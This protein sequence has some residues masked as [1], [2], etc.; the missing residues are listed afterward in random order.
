MATGD[1][2]NAFMAQVGGH[3][4]N[5]KSD[6]T[7]A[8]GG[9]FITRNLNNIV[10]GIGAGGAVALGAAL[11]P[12][13][14][15][16]SLIPALALAAGGGA[17]GGGLGEASK[18]AAEGNYG[19][20]QSLKEIRNQAL[21]QG[22]LGAAGEGAGSL[23]GHF[24]PAATEGGGAITRGL[25]N[26]SGKKIAQQVASNLPKDAL[27][28]GNDVARLTSNSELLSGLG[29]YNNAQRQTAG[30]L[31]NDFLGS[32]KNEALSK[33]GSV[34]IL[35]GLGQKI[36]AAITD[37]GVAQGDSK[38]I[39]G[40]VNSAVNK[41]IGSE[42]AVGNQAASAADVFKIQSKLEK[43]GIAAS[44]SGDAE[45]AAAYRDLASHFAN[46]IDTHAG[47]NASIA[48]LQV[49]AEQAAQL[50]Q[51]AISALGKT[52]GT[53]L[54][55][56]LIE[57]VNRA[58]VGSGSGGGLADVRDLLSSFVPGSK[59]ATAATISG[60]QKTAPSVLETVPGAVV[61]P[62]G[63]LGAVKSVMG[64]LAAPEAALAGR[65]AN[66]TGGIGSL[67]SKAAGVIGEAA[68]AIPAAA[69]ALTGQTPPSEVGAPTDGTQA[70]PQDQS[71][72]QTAPDQG[73]FSPSV[74]QAM[75]LHDIQTTGGKNI[76][77]ISTLANLFGPNSKL[78]STPKPTTAQQKTA[79]DM[80]DALSF[81]DTAEAQIKDLG[82]AKGPLNA[83]GGLPLVGGFI[84]PKVAAY[85]QTKIDLATALAKALTGSAR[86]ASA[87]IKRFEQSLPQPTDAPAVA[88]Q[89]LSNLRQELGNKINNS[90]AISAL[91]NGQ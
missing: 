33:S 79:S 11:A 77:K 43:L 32:V 56:H 61:S 51:R 40:A 76:D 64:R 41:A 6:A 71:S 90:P 50:T 46:L 1:L 26:L 80:Q 14:G 12:E 27:Q 9:D 87:V 22:G 20:S 19:S 34:P 5:A 39:Q 84:Q 45:K 49:P 36:T 47:T 8:P 62:M 70:A 28:T 38:A 82:G 58:G 15:G 52:K 83:L 10:G 63:K 35:D 74:L 68:P 2:H 25:E 31:A 54:A 48:A 23:V 60:L 3:Q 81:L 57:G 21:I 13:T 37:N 86:P 16:L 69:R 53:A 85:N 24:L 78:S 89:K 30:N 29:L 65:A 67:A 88:D 4:I 55:D 42:G 66:I 72:A 7:V 44:R 75:A 73:M 18:Q 91:I 17:I 59:A